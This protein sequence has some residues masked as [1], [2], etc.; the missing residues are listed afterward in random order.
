MSDDI[1]ARLREMAGTETE[2]VKPI[3]T[4]AKA[5][6]FVPT[7]VKPEQVSGVPTTVKGKT[8][9][10]EPVAKAPSLPIPVVVLDDGSTFS[11]LRGCKVCFVD[12]DAEEI[13]ADALASGIKVSDLLTLRDALHTV[14]RIVD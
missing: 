12:P 8:V 2:P 5:E 9:V 4:K 3:K 6:T 10:A 14:L 1:L 7:P 13:D 11:N